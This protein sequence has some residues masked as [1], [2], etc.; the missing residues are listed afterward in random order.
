MTKA[1][2]NRSQQG[3]ESSIKGF[4]YER[5]FIAL[6]CA[7]MIGKKQ[8]IIKI[9]CEYK[10]DIEIISCDHRLSSWQIKSTKGNTLPT[11][12]VY[13]SVKLFNRINDT[14]EYSEFILACNRNFTNMDMQMLVIY[15]LEDFPDLKSKIQKKFDGRLQETFP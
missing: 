10:N 3:G 6:L 7:W 8:D 14:A 5:D 12:E 15:K 13:E 9:I 11:M 1:N 4:R 2:V